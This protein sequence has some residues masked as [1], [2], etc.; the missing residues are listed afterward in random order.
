MDS[1]QR[2]VQTDMKCKTNHQGNSTW[3]LYIPN[4]SRFTTHVNLTSNY[5]IFRNVYPI[6]STRVE[7]HA[8]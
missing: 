4:P 8:Q 3:Q 6:Y 2:E 7:K 5:P 1:V